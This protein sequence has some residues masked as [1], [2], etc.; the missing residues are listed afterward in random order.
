M[1]VIWP[2]YINSTTE[3]CSCRIEGIYHY[4]FDQCVSYC[5]SE[6][7]IE[8][9]QNDSVVFHNISSAMSGFFVHFICDRTPC[10]P[11]QPCYLI[12]IVSSHSVNIE[13]ISRWEYIIWEEDVQWRRFH[14]TSSPTT[15]IAFNPP[16][17]LNPPS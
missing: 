3:L 13:G 8:L 15:L 1:K 12:T 10:G 9:L 16:P 6:Y 4:P 5:K 14:S 2:R 7:Q 11:D 17:L